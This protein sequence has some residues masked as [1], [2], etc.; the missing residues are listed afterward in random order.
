MP[1]DLPSP[2]VILW[3][4]ADAVSCLAG[5]LD[6]MGA[7]VDPIGI[8]GP[9]R[10][11]ISDL[12]AGLELEP[13]DDLRKL[14]VDRPAAFLV[15]GTM[16]GVAAADLLTAAGQGTAVL[17]LEPVAAGLPELD[18]LRPASGRRRGAAAAAPPAGAFAFIPAFSRAAGFRAAAEPHDAIGEPR[19]ISLT[20][21]GQPHHGSLFARLFDAWHTI[22]GFAGLPETIDASLTSANL[23]IPDDPRRLKGHVAA[24]A[25]LTDGGSVSL[26]VSAHAAETRRQ[27]EIIGPEGCLHVTDN[28]YRLRHA[29]GSEVDH[30]QATPAQP[31]FADLIADQWRLALHRP[32]SNDPQPGSPSARYADTLACCLAGLLSA[33]TGEPESPQRLLD[34]NR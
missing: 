2:E 24:H 13:Y 17:S 9:H 15:L 14:V 25:R 7:A 6:Q 5:A 34:M 21:L 26:L 1:D 27:F 16:E 32:I 22:L 30:A 18:A 3:T 10:G 28:A 33:R 23:D 31:P 4:D 19:A 12:A 29:D 11:A 20:S 8:G